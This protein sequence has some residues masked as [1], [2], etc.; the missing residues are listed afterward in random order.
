MDRVFKTILSF[1]D[2][3][4]RNFNSVRSLIEVLLY[5]LIKLV[6]FFDLPLDSV[7][8]FLRIALAIQI[9][10]GSCSIAFV[11]LLK[12]V[13]LVLFFETI[14]LSFL[15]VAHFILINSCWFFRF[16]NLFL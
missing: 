5:F 12:V 13:I 15:F 6:S 7:F 16:F 8:L 14:A 3:V 4:D 1:K 10:Q 9:L 11:V 2:V